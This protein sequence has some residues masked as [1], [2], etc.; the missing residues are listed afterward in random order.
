M[1]KFRSLIV[2]M[3]FL[4]A[5]RIAFAQD[6]TI[7][8]GEIR[9]DGTLVSYDA[10]GKKLVM[11]VVSFSLPNGKTSKLAAPKPKT[12]LLATETKM[13]VVGAGETEAAPLLTAGAPVMV[14]A[15]EAGTGKDVTARLVMVAPPQAGSTP[16]AEEGDP[17]DVAIAPGETRFDARVTGILS[18]TNITASVFS[19]TDH[20]GETQELFPT[21]TKTIVLDAATP[22]RS[23]GDVKRKL[24]IG[25]LKIGSRV[26]FSGK[27]GGGAK[28]KASELAI[29]EED[30]SKSESIGSVSISGPVSILLKRADQATDA[31]A[32]EEG[33]KILTTALR[34]AESIDDRAG[35]GLTL[36]RL[37]NAYE[38]MNQPQK[39]LEHFEK[40]L[41]VWRGLGD[42]QNES[43][44]LNNLGI[45][46]QRTDQTEKAVET[47][48]RAVKLSRGGDPRGMAL[49]LQNLAGAY[50]DADKLDKS[51]ETMLEALPFVR[52]TRKTVDDEAMLLAR[53]ARAYGAQKNAAKT[54]EYS[55]QAI[56]LIDQV[57]EKNAQAYTSR[58]IAAAY[59]YT[60]QKPKALEFYKRAQVLYD[61]LEQ[62]DESEYV[63]KAI[64][65]LDKPAA[66]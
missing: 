14:I 47:L 37:A 51:I 16:G 43:T 63:A 29:W 64:V 10:A 48:E 52:Q 44:T 61:E 62:K 33:I 35:R 56:A 18:A 50:S 66:E 57:G 27:D 28:I 40:A 9:F 42:T 19:M 65:E 12:V 54:N 49:T 23:R 22:V 24:T 17:N 13:A 6:V 31:K 46:Y 2:A 34:T 60:G 36:D 58:V 15:K 26:T 55:E 11:N 45:F 4:L 21:L 38:E 7:A 5:A 1:L 25:D 3:V 20:K 39:A 30:K 41:S 53:I 59:G 32:Y 8:A